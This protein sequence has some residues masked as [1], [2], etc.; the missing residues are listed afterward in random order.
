M[1]SVRGPL[2]LPQV[3]KE[4]CKQAGIEDFITKVTPIAV[5]NQL[6][7]AVL[8][9]VPWHVYTRLLCTEQRVPAA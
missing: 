5:L 2:L 3:L 7:I 9:S 6:H 8:H 1:W 4:Q